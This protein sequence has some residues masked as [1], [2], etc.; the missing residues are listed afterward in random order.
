M[1][2]GE[3]DT[4]SVGQDH[5]PAALIVNTRSRTGERAFFRALDH[6]QELHVPVG[7]TYAVRDPA[8]RLWV[9]DPGRRRRVRELR[10]RLPGRPRY[11]SGAPA[12]GYGQ[13]LR[14]DTRHPR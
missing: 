4:E 11:A 12:P 5:G 14:Q 3:K 2:D 6:L 9:P 7:V 8:R 10:C 1:P 13:R